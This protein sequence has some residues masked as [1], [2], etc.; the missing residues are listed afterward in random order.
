MT[1]T[2]SKPDSTVS[3]LYLDVLTE[4]ERIYKEELLP[5]ENLEERVAAFLEKR[6]P[7]WRHR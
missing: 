2:S 1:A 4:S 5:L 3:Y 7:A 6:R